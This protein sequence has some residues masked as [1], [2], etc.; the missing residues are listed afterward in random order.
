MRVTLDASVFVS[1]YLASDVHHTESVSLLGRLIEVKIDL[2]APVLVLAEV[3]AALA[4]N[5][6]DPKRGLAGKEMLEQTPRLQL[7]PLSLP[8]GKSAAGLASAHFLRGADA[9]YVALASSTGSVLV[10]WDQE[11]RQR[12]SAATVTLTPTEWLSHPPTDN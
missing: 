8:L 9:V 6:H 11:M 4:R 12:G 2:N 10:T 3:A 5:T 7:Y 1:A